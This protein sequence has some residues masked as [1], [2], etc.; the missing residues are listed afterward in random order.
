MIS[1]LVASKVQVF[2]VPTRPIQSMTV[3]IKVTHAWYTVKKIPFLK[4]DTT[5]NL[6]PRITLQQLTAGL[7]KPK[8]GI[9]L[10][11]VYAKHVKTFVF[12]VRK[13]ERKNIYIQRSR[14]KLPTKL[15]FVLCFPVIYFQIILVYKMIF[16][17]LRTALS[18]YLTT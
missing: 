16:L 8:K 18:R 12:L 1:F 6:V 17:F 10:N 14:Q 15:P 9:S 5:C 4:R 7:L 3:I 11:K 2:R 13:Q